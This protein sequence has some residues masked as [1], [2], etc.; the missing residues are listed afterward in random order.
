MMQEKKHISAMRIKQKLL[1]LYL[2]V[3]EFFVILHSTIQTYF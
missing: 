2:K 1:Y 3:E